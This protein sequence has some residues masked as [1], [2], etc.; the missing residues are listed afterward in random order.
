MAVAARAPRADV[1]IG[2]DPDRKAPLFAHAWIEM[3]G[4]AVDPQDV[5]GAVIARL[6]GPES[7][8]RAGAHP[9]R[10]A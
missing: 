2:V 6:R 8:L 3:D 9:G 1:A 7:A 4:I 5:A 10:P